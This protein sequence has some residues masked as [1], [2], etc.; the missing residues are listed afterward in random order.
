[1]LPNKKTESNPRGA[2]NDRIQ[3]S[4]V[5][6]CA[7]ASQ[8]EAFSPMGTKRVQSA[9]ITDPK[10]GEHSGSQKRVTVGSHIAGHSLRITINCEVASDSKVGVCGGSITAT[11]QAF[12][13]TATDV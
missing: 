13:I 9:Q 1:M 5:S 6:P 2:G 7:H 12:R 11:D 4:D 8:Q 10:I 3:V